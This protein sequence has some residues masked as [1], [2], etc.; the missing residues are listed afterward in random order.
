[1]AQI[2]SDLENT[3]T[4]GKLST[5]AVSLGFLVEIFFI[6]LSSLGFYHDSHTNPIIFA[7][8]VHTELGAPVG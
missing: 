8:H 3:H 5:M 7:S 6:Y 2:A 4:G 1:M